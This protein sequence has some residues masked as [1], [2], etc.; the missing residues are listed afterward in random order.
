M[1]ALRRLHDRGNR[2]IALP[3]KGHDRLR[4]RPAAAL[5]WHAP[6]AKGFHANDAAKAEV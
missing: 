6:A 3:V 5:D 4:R 2:R 1:S